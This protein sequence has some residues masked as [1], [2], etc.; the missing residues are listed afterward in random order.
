[1]TGPPPRPEPVRSD[2]EITVGGQTFPVVYR[3]ANRPGPV[4][5]DLDLSQLGGLA[6][7]AHG[8]IA[9]FNQRVYDAAADIVCEQDVAVTLRDGTTIYC[10][11][12]RPKDSGPVPVIV[13]WSAYGKRPGDA[14]S[15]WVIPGVPL[16][17]VST[18]AKFESADPAYWC[19]IGYAVANVDPRG[20][21]YSEGDIE[22]FGPQDAQDGYDFVE[23]VASRPWCTGKVGMAGNSMVAMTQ[24]RIAAQQPPHLAAIAPWEAS[25]DMYRDLLLEGGIPALTFNEFI[26]GSL[27]GQGLVD[28]LVAN[29]LR[30]PLMHPYWQSKIPDF[31]KVTVP[32]YVA[33]GWSHIHLRGTM[34]A[35]RRIASPDKWLRCY[36]EH[37]WPVFYVRESV[38]DL[39]AF[40]DRYLRDIHNGWELTPRV[41]LDVMDAYDVDYQTSRPET[42]FP[43]ERTEYR[44]IYLDTKVRALVENPPS[45]SASASY[46]PQ[47]E[48]LVFDLEFTDETE[49][50]GYLLLHLWVE[51]DGHDDMDLFV[52][53]K[54]ADADGGLVPWSILGQPHPG[55]W[56]K[57]RVSHRAL[58]PALSTEFN[59]VQSHVAEEKLRPGQV[60]PVDIEI[61][62]SSRVWH[63]GERLRLEI[64]GR[65]IRGDWFEP[66][67]WETDNSGRH[68]VHTGGD[69]DSYLQ[70][71]VIPPRRKVGGYL[72]R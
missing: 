36:R 54:K 8:F 3:E 26:V 30:Y 48:A 71:P 59:P 24:L 61:V 7:T 64:A 10:D 51:A 45:A 17:T 23:W 34:N 57:M 14:M 41:Q 11:I 18:M 25:S 13:S 37:E 33:V 35:W 72:A 68:V 29:A 56:G 12:Y 28:D 1:M 46:D 42:A 27:S 44:R 60:V 70:I 47:T 16:G 31:T 4:P 58:D 67:S 21:G 49:L 40:F 53:V 62:A 50:S 38:A 69:Y 63:Q 15:Q 22:L 55:A 6:A 39:T 9:P 43:I 52:T 20:V 5:P 2:K 66:L 32:A 65:Y 19:R